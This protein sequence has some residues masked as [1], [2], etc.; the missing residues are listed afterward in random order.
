[1]LAQYLDLTE[2]FN[3]SSNGISFEVSN[4]DYCLIQI[5]N[6]TGD[7]ID[8]KATIDSGAIQ[9]ITDGSALLATNFVPVA[10]TN[11]LNGSLVT[12]TGGGANSIYRLD[13]VGRFVNLFCSGG[14][15]NVGKLLIM[16]AK[17]S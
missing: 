13:V 12:N 11:I 14:D 17:I 4:Y 1:M 2:D 16:L 9:S 5:I 7:G 6:N 3:N 8:F 10:A 15:T